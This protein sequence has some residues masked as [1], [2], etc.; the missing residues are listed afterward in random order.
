MIYL[1]YLMLLALNGTVACSP[2]LNV[3]SQ[4]IPERDIAAK[5]AAMAGAS[6]LDIDLYTPS[7]VLPGCSGKNELVV[8]TIESPT[9]QS[10]L[11]QAQAYS[12][13]Q[14]GLALMVIHQDALIYESYADNVSVRSRTESFSMMKSV[15]SLMVGIALE[16]GVIKNVDDPIGN[17]L[18]EWRN[19]P[20][21]R[22]TIRQLLTMS[23][24]LQSFPFGVPGGETEKLLYSTNINAVAL[25]YPL[26][27][28]PGAVFQYNNVNSQLIGAA[29]DR[30]LRRQG[31]GSFAKFMQEN[32]WCP[33]GNG[34]ATLWLDRKGGS[35]HF[36]SGLQASARDWARLGELI[37]N[38]GKVGVKQIVPQNWI[39]EM[40][41]PS[42]TNPAYGLHIWR[43]QAWQNVRKY[44]PASS[45]GVSHSEAY[46]APDVYFFDGF[47]GQRVYIIPSE[48]LTI[49]RVGEASMTYDDSI[50]VNLL[51]AAI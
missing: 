28:T 12:D 31:N 29:I 9:L 21:E 51:L 4:P 15:T 25:G 19:D 11:Q 39:S 10:A 6:I 49:V 38:Q 45:F 17:Y 5:A 47:G 27:G 26:S 13:S 42:D 20:R 34:E 14:S 40:L 24:G 22:I 23:S 50:I 18:D 3:P 1:R 43:G 35:P 7:A 32:L 8:R 33:L 46:L 36:Y 41:R 44:D 16:K 30:S 2:N 37:R 48:N